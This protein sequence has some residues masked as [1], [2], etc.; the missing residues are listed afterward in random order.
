MLKK[1]VAILLT[2]VIVS[3]AFFINRYMHKKDTSLSLI[4]SL[5]IASDYA[6]NKNK[7]LKLI[8]ATSVDY[9]EK[10]SIDKGTNGKRLVWNFLFG[11]VDSNKGLIVFVTEG[12][13]GSV[14][15]VS[16]TFSTSD[17]ISIDDILLD[18]KD[19]IKISR[20][21]YQLKPGVNFAVGYHYTLNKVEKN[22]VLSVLGLDTDGYMTNISYDAKSKTKLRIEHKLPNGGKF[23]KNNININLS[24]NTP[25]SANKVFILPSEQLYSTVITS[26]FINPYSSFMK[27]AASISYDSGKSWTNIKFNQEIIDILF[28]K[29]YVDDN[30]AYIITPNEVFSSTDQF[31]SFKSLLK[32]NNEN[33]IKA[34]YNKPT[35]IVLTDKKLYL[36]NVFSS[37]WKSIDIPSETYST[38]IDNSGN[39]YAVTNKS[40]Y[41]R[42]N[43][44]WREIAFPEQISIRDL[45]VSD[46]QLILTNYKKLYIL[47]IP[48]KK[49][50]IVMLNNNAIGMYDGS[51]SY[52]KNTFYILFDNNSL[53]VFERK[54][55]SKEWT[56][57]KV[58]NIN[59]ANLQ[60]I[61]C[62]SLGNNFICTSAKYEWSEIRG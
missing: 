48:S 45:V 58:P 14:K 38:F 10:S 11:D 29:S 30:F 1:L 8:K 43:E 26:Y 47:D 12:K 20:N 41:V 6:Y 31:N 56:S 52:S 25:I 40:L 54:E 50:S 28:S 35:L 62:D 36:S 37:S 2:L 13:I 46:N 53:N 34:Y 61:K 21:N 18:S 44:A 27:P 17:Y 16:S 42:E 15:E 7:N 59:T 19:I 55:G 9:P 39:I 51:H 60:D 57:S 22:I 49:W 24:G 23:L 5:K 3:S 33:I 4:E 32:L